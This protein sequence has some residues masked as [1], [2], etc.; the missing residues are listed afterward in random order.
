MKKKATIL[1][2]STIVLVTI[3]LTILGFSVKEETTANPSA[4][5]S[6]IY[7][8]CDACGT[9]DYVEVFWTGYTSDCMGYTPEWCD[10]E[11]TLYFD[12]Y[13]HI[14]HVLNDHVQLGYFGVKI[15]ITKVGAQC[16]YYETK[17]VGDTCNPSVMSI[18]FDVDYPWNCPN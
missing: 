18:T 4:N 7:I 17:Y 1:V 16:N 3:I 5:Y 6:S 2:G 10:D 15:I 8:D 14:E 9:N 12:S 13:G 11:G